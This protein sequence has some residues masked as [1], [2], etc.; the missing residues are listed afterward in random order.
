[1]SRFFLITSSFKEHKLLTILGLVFVFLATL[2]S[3]LGPPQLILQ[4]IHADSSTVYKPGK[5]VFDY[6]GNPWDATRFD[7]FGNSLSLLFFVFAIAYMLMVCFIGRSIISSFLIAEQK[8]PP[9]PLLLAGFLI[10]YTSILLPLRLLYTVFQSDL[11]SVLSIFILLSWSIRSISNSPSN[12]AKQITKGSFW[13]FT[14]F[15]VLAIV[16]RIQSGRN[17][18]V[19]DS[20]LVFLDYA[21]LFKV[22][23][24]DLGYLPTWDQQ[25]DEWIFTA[26]GVFL[27][28]SDQ[29]DSLWYLVTAAFG[30]ISLF[31]SIFLF[32]RHTLQKL[33]RTLF[34]RLG[35]WIPPLLVFFSTPSLLPTGYRSLFGGQN[36]VIYL[37][38][39]GRYLGLLLPWILIFLLSRG[40]SKS[41]RLSSKEFLFF[42]GIGFMSLHLTVY[43]FLF[44]L[45]LLFIQ[46]ARPIFR[47]STSSP[48]NKSSSFFR[49]ELMVF[50]PALLSLIV[51]YM[52]NTRDVALGSVSV[53]NQ[54]SWSSII[55]LL[56]SLFSLFLFILRSDG[57]RLIPQ[58]H[59]PLKRFM[60]Y[61]FAIF[62]GFTIS[63][64][65]IFHFEIFRSGY[66]LLGKILPFY[67]TE[68]YSR[69][70]INDITFEPFVFSGNECWVTG[71]CLSISGFIGSFGLIIMLV[72]MAI[73]VSL[74]SR[75][76]PTIFET[77]FGLSIIF[78]PLMFF[79]VDFTG[80]I[81]LGSSWIKTRFLEP[82]YYYVLVLSWLMITL[83]TRYRRI[84]IFFSCLWFLPLVFF[85]VIPQ[86]QANLLWLIRRSM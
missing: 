81:G 62:F 16:Y 82:A 86:I 3:I 56:G 84:F 52:L 26:P 35:A 68:P 44:G 15:A 1:M 18:L 33:P 79:I 71:H 5:V 36:P 21:K 27:I 39:P 61:L 74:K 34:I 73:T 9:I 12:P 43:V 64:N 70:L 42:S 50:M 28:K 85:R 19:S 31:C 7:P 77:L 17:F 45:A 10:G 66:K 29:Y 13:L 20:N 55:L 22:D 30:Q 65:A 76:T 49:S 46:F 8:I 23:D 24:M 63:G 51:V 40:K 41:D 4:S 83:Y 53:D 14:L 59:R 57:A 67:Q 78:L 69:G 48:R 38:H 72:F 32:S 2:V 80:G 25:S 75:S 11:A 54:R 6:F 47:L 58:F 37:G 60:L